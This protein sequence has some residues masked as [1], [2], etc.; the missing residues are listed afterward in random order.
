MEPRRSLDE[1]RS[2]TTASRVAPRLAVGR[3]RR[4]PRH[5]R[6]DRRGRRALRRPRYDG[7]GTRPGRTEPATAPKHRDRRPARSTV[8]FVGDTSHGPCSTR[9]T[10][11][12]S[13]ER[14]LGVL[15][16]AID[17]A[18]H[19]PD[20]RSY[21]PKGTRRDARDRRRTCP[22]APCRSTSPAGPDGPPRRCTAAEAELSVEQARVG[23]ER[24]RLRPEPGDV[25]V[26][27]QPDGHAARRSRPSSPC[28]RL[29][30]RHALAGAGRHPGRRRHRSPARSRSAAAQRR[31]RPTSS[32]S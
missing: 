4:G 31:S 9:R 3:R 30:G 5:R 2:R 15:Q 11:R 23:A 7:R 17:G 19:D 28:P 32:G 18:A 10:A 20:Y 26:D 27:G 16:D 25:P 8:Y 12:A 6:D 21:W 14:R 1:I 29:G 22:T 13:R 24:V